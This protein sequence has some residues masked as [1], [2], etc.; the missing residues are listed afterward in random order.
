MHTR[1]GY[2]YRVILSD[3]MLKQGFKPKI[4]VFD[5]YIKAYFYVIVN[6]GSGSL[7][8][9]K[10]QMGLFIE[11]VKDKKMKYKL[12]HK[13]SLKDKK[14]L[15]ISIEEVKDMYKRL[16]E[17]KDICSFVFGIERVKE[18]KPS[19]EGTNILKTNDS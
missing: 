6:W 1:K 16:Q 4:K 7:D 13:R 15:Y 11:E 8:Y 2:K 18:S 5:T 19:R 9:S 3:N 10:N 14:D 12:K 17:D